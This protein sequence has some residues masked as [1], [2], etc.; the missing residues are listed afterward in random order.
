MI[1]GD[2]HDERLELPKMANLQLFI[3]IGV[4]IELLFALRPTVSEI[5]TTEVSGTFIPN[6]G[7]S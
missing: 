7:L 5:N 4:E 2:F 3:A 6:R 1:I